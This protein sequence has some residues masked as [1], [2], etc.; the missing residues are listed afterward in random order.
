M[1]RPLAG[2]YIVMVRGTMVLNLH[3]FLV[4]LLVVA[5]ASGSGRKIAQL[6]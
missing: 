2:Y 3:P 1:K 5:G 4:H 6:P